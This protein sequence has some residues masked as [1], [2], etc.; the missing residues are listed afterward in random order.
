MNMK[1]FIFVLVGILIFPLVNSVCEQGQIN[2]NTASKS[3]L[4]EIYQIGESRAEQIIQLRLFE[5]IDDLT[6]VNG[7]AEK[8][9]N[10]IKNEGLACVGDET[11]QEKNISKTENET[12][13]T[14][15]DSEENINNNEN[16]EEPVKT[17]NS[18]VKLDLNQNSSKEKTDSKDIK[19]PANKDINKDKIAKY[20]LAG[21]CMFLIIIY[22][23]K[24]KKT[25]KNEFR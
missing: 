12:N 9:L 14:N 13:S 6:M 20:G 18:P 11:S 22:L 5:S 24:N 15:F 19:K 3:E 17:N 23:T 7:I 1:I 10:E 25:Y 21:F 16:N 4:D 2:I 8:T